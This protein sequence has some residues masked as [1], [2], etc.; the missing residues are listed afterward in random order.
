MATKKKD[1]RWMNDH[2]DAHFPDNPAVA[3]KTKKKIE[4]LPKGHPAVKV[5]KKKSTVRKKSI[6]K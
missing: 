4:S 1:K 6:T 3:K 2:D 5:T